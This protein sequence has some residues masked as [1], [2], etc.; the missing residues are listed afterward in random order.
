[1]VRLTAL[2][3]RLWPFGDDPAEPTVDDGDDSEGTVWDAIP[4][5]QYEGRFAEAGGITRGE[6]ERALA[7]VQS[8]AAAEDEVPE[9]RE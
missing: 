1:M 2:L 5:W 4:S 3:R 9:H 7:D 6:Q 8:R